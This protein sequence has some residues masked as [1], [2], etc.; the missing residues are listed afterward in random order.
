M[1]GEEQKG[2]DVYFIKQTIGN[3]CGTMGLIHAILG[4]SDKIKLDGESL[5]VIEAIYL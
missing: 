2:A 1:F 5:S 4:N 3:A